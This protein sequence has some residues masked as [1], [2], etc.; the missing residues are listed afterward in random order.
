M[1]II[2]NIEPTVGEDDSTKILKVLF[3]D[4]NSFFEKSEK[5]IS[6]DKLEYSSKKILTKK[7]KN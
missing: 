7:I 1:E 2:N 3:E 5:I 4:Q 6:L